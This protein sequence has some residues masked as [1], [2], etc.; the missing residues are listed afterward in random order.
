MALSD[1]GPI[2]D[3]TRLEQGALAGVVLMLLTGCHPGNRAGESNVP[4]RAGQNGSFVTASMTT[5]KVPVLGRDTIAKECEH[6]SYANASKGLIVEEAGLHED[7]FS[8]RNRDAL[9]ATAYNLDEALHLEDL[10]RAAAKASGR[11]AEQG[12]C[13]DAFAQHFGTLTDGL[14][15]ADKVQRELDMAAFNEATKEA[16]A[17]DQ[18]EKDRPEKDQT[19]KEP[20]PESAQPATSIPQ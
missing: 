16:Q 13:M 11:S 10:L 6:E 20:S 12:K 18:L 1:R 9:T 15:Q 8:L 4:D 3:R 2:R 17:E 14:L 5:D 19:E 7:V